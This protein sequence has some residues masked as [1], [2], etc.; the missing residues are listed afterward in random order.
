MLLKE[1]C[2]GDWRGEKSNLLISRFLMKGKKEPKG[3]VFGRI[4]AEE[5]LCVPAADPSICKKASK[6]VEERV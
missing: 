4:Y 1:A 5:V 6:A 2:V 3:I